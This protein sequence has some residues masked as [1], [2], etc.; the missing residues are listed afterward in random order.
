MNEPIYEYVRGQGWIVSTG[1]YTYSDGRRVRIEERLPR[2]GENIRE[3]AIGS[4]AD[5]MGCV[6]WIVSRDVHGYPASDNYVLDAHYK[7]FVITNV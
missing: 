3:I 7:V 6:E 1:I 2:R 4:P 5:R